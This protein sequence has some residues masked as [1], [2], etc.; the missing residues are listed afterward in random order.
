MT[1]PLISVVVPTRNEKEN[2]VRLIDSV[3]QNETSSYEIIVVDGGSED[4]TDH[5]AREKG[6]RVIQ[7]PQK[8]PSVARDRGWRQAKGEYIY[9]LDADFYL[10]PG[11]LDTIVSFIQKNPGIESIGTHVVYDTQKSWVSECIRIEN[12][13]SNVL[14]ELWRGVV[15]AIKKISS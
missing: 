10:E 4:G 15:N 14:N 12:L 2:I 11:A 8:G 3:N 13:S 7:G 5:I 6:A 1:D 9:F